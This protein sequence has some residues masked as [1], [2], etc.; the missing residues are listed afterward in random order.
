MLPIVGIIIYIIYELVWWDLF[1]FFN[2]TVTQLIGM[3]IVLKTYTSF[4]CEVSVI[5]VVCIMQC[6]I[7]VHDSYLACR[8]LTPASSTTEPYGASY[9]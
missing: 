1:I 5:T 9:C 4:C 8:V 6:V 3:E 7:L 2:L